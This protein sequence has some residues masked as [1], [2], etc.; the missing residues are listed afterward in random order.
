MLVHAL[1]SPIGASPEP[2]ILLVLDSFDK[3]LADL[4]GGRA[5]VAM[6]AEDN[7]AKLLL[8]PLV[9]GIGLLLLLLGLP[10]VGVQILLGG[11]ALDVQVMTELAL[12][13]LFATALLVELTQHGLRVHA[14]RHLLSLDGLEQLSGLTLG[15]LGSFLVG[16]TL[17]LLGGFALVIGCLV[18]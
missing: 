18:R 16:L 5:W 14:E 1:I 4:F 12:A 13:A 3:V 10:G 6:L 9:H 8:V 2:T 11:L 17:G 15:L 7:A